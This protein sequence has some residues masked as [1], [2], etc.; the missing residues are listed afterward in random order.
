MARVQGTGGVHNSM[1]IENKAPYLTLYLGWIPPHPLPF[2]PFTFC[3]ELV[4]PH[5]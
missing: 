5:T 3:W 2:L 4:W 1:L